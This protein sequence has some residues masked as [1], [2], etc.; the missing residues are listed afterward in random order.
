MEVLDFIALIRN[1]APDLQA[2][3]FSEGACYQFYLILKAMYPQAV[4][5]HD[6]N[7]VITMIDGRFYDITGEVK[8]GNHEL[9]EEVPVNWGRTFEN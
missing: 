3:I 4:P 1:S 8:R 5:Y 6:M 2:K 7:H 9:M